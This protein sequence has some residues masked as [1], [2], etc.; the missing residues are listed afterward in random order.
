M[1]TYAE[2][3]SRVQNYYNGQGDLTD[4]DEEYTTPSD[5]TYDTDKV[6][7]DGETR[8]KEGSNPEATFFANFNTDINGTWGDGVLIGTAYG[9]AAIL[10]AELDLTG[11]G[12]KYTEYSGV[13][14]INST[15]KG[16]VRFKY[17]SN[18]SGGPPSWYTLFELQISDGINTDEIYLS[19]TN[20]SGGQLY[21]QIR[22]SGS[23]IVS[24]YFG[25]WNPTSGVKYEFELNWDVNI[26]AHRLFILNPSTGICEQFG[27]TKTGTGT[28]TALNHFKIGTNFNSTDSMNGKFEDFIIFSDV[29]HTSNY[30]PSDYAIYS[31]LNDIITPISGLSSSISIYSWNSFAETSTKL[32]SDE[33]KY[34]LSDDDGVT[35]QYYN[36][37]WISSN[38]AYSQAN[39]AT[40]INAQ[41]SSFPVTNKKLLIRAFLHSTDGTT[42]PELDNLAI[43]YY[44]N[45]IPEMV[46]HQI[47][48]V[49]RGNLW[50]YINIKQ[51]NEEP[52]TTGAG[53]INRNNQE[54]EIT[55]YC[56][57]QTDV[58]VC[59]SELY[60]V[61]RLENLVSWGHWNVLVRKPISR[62]NNAK[63]FFRCREIKLLV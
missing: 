53:S 40:E 15:Q 58:E 7:V 48:S 18:Y 55:I 4:Y 44:I 27:T 31:M 26:G 54:F 42:T 59:Q 6:E 24:S 52:A 38:E 39:T 16:A 28:I 36:S 56:T 61:I 33:I 51:Q 9:G 8:L 13:D 5:Y 60:R 32:G 20:I 19:H 22:G 47:T 23:G 43:G 3:V 49:R 45:K 14:N 12:I 29:Q 62:P 63:Y 35:W 37:G 57:N 11:G 46:N 10:N 17:T 30:T 2:V 1:V 34:I 21:L 25:V 41:F 50:L